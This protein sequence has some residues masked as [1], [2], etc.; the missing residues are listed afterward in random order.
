MVVSVG[1]TGDA[2]NDGCGCERASFHNICFGLF[3]DLTIR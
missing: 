2:K 1:V 3:S